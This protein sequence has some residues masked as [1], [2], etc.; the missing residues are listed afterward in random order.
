MY[1]AQPL[2]S[3]APSF[4]LACFGTDKKFNTQHVLKRWKYIY[5]ECYKR[6]ITVISFGADGNNVV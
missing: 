2:C 1:M 3:N 4:C 5:T 6:G